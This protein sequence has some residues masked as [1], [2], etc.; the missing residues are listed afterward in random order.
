M[1][2]MLRQTSGRNLV[3]WGFPAV[4][5]GGVRAGPLL[6]NEFAFSRYLSLADSI[7]SRLRIHRGSKAGA[8]RI[9]AGPGRKIGVP[10]K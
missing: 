9:A 2:Y 7:A 4:G 10:P 3:R 6:P 1:N 8:A 5:S